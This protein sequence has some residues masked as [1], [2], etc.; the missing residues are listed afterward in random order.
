[1]TIDVT[2]IDGPTKALEL[3]RL[4]KRRNSTSGKWRLSTL[5][6]L[7]SIH[8][9]STNFIVSHCRPWTGYRYPTSAM[10]KR[11]RRLIEEKY[12][13]DVVLSKLEPWLDQIASLPRKI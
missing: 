7:S 11:A 3:T 5:M 9:D 12:S 13:W 4:S 8:Q 10:S 1:M 6:L 2:E